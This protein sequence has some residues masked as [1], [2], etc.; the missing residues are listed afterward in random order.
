MDFRPLILNQQADSLKVLSS[1][2]DNIRPGRLE[3]T[4]FASD[5]IRDLITL[6]RT[7]SQCKEALKNHVSSL[8]ANTSSLSL[9]TQSGIFST[10][11]FFSDLSQKV[12]HS[13]LP[14]LRNFTDMGDVLTTLFHKSWDHKW[15]VEVHD[16][17]WMELVKE[18]ELSIKV[19]PDGKELNEF[20]NSILI[21]S[22]RI[23]VLGLDPVL[24]A[25]VPGINDL[26][27][28]F[29]QQNK[30]I[31][32]YIEQ[33][34]GNR[35]LPSGEVTEYRY[36]LNT[37]E[38]CVQKILYVRINK[39]TIGASMGLT[40]VTQ[41]LDQ[42]VSRIRSL[43]KILHE[44]DAVQERAIIKLF[45]ELV[46]HQSTK[47][48]LT[49]HISEN[50]G[51]LA[52]QVSE[53]A[54]KTGEHYISNDRKEYFKIF[55]YSL[56]G[57]FIVAFLVC[58]KVFLYYQHLPPL[59]NAIMSGMNYGVGFIVI[60]MCGFML[61]TKQP[62]MTASKLAGALEGHT[63][64]NIGISNL[65]QLIVKIS[66][67]QFVSFAGNLLMVFPTVW[68]LSWLY[69]FIA[70]EHIADPEKAT[71]LISELNPVYSLSIWYASIAG[72][73]L[74]M[75]GLISG[76]FDN[77]TVFNKFPERIVNHPALKWVSLP[78]RQKI[79]GYFENNLGSLAGNFI[80]G[81]LLA[82]TPFIGYILGLPLDVRHVTFVTGSF[83]L[84]LEGFSEQINS[85]VIVVTLL[86][87]VA[88]GLANFVVSFGLAIFT[89]IKARQ[90]RFR[91]TW[92]LMNLLKAYFFT[93]PLD[94]FFPP[95]K[96][97]IIN[98][99]DDEPK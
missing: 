91:Q 62:A 47:T 85:D 28:P 38:R 24:I 15:V 58:F 92:K 23:V 96:E 1:I 48:N 19:F 82:L 22:H 68:L 17:L 65:A 87:I 72:V 9:F 30:E 44:R 56:G 89:A 8:F 93:Y 12:K 45:K 86:S 34:K 54:A 27:S 52:Y 11:G 18:I 29:F 42:H 71:T 2:I 14:P 33:I 4:R 75:S 35:I 95:A 88:I 98:L 63:Q 79:A 84:G 46:N 60:H 3:S 5:R 37:L 64:D 41:R 43:L 16:Q 6:L 77:K 70:G 40:Y 55:K 10:G 13:I 59:L 74:F 49:I 90:V 83:G 50:I 94:F 51:L 7:D 57:G 67:T 20:L 69:F 21:L 53:H 25:K 31:T 39:N 80:L 32:D 66:R 76:Y 26:D 97:R 99:I 61:A 81:F 78:K 36:I 73:L